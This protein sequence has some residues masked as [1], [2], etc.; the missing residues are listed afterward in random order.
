MSKILHETYEKN[1]IIS[2]IEQPSPN[3]MPHAQIHTEYELYYLVK[4]ERYYFIE[5][6]IYLITP[7]TLVLINS[8]TVHRTACVRPNTSHERIL[9]IFNG[10]FI[11]PTLSKLGVPPLSDL[12]RIPVIQFA[13]ADQELLQKLFHDIITEQTLKQAS[14]H[15]AIKL[16]ILELLLLISRHNAFPASSIASAGLISEKHKKVNEAIFYIKEHFMEPL[17][18]QMIADSVFVS[19]GYLSNI[20]NETTGMKL[21]D[22]INIQRINYAKTLLYSSSANITDIAEKCGYDSITYFERIFKQL[23]GVTPLKFKQVQKH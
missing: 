16:K 17:S 2:H 5:D 7:N 13:P 12:F 11:Q 10:D 3:D 1:Y 21:T 22:Y 18:L 9:L 14:Y 6:A 23:T 20:F 8:G 19:R 4:G 15:A